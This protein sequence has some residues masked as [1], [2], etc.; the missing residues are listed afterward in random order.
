M[1]EPG[2]AGRAVTPAQV[3]QVLAIAIVMTNH[4]AIAFFHRD[5]HEVARRRFGA[6]AE[7]RV[8][9]HPVKPGE[10]IPDAR[11]AMRESWA[12]SA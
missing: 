11:G 2:G 9:G 7:L 6:F 1:K 12:C 4:P 10:E 8:T 3:E 5:R